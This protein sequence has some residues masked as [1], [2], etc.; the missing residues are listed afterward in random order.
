MG[1][2]MIFGMERKPEKIP[3]STLDNQHVMPTWDSPQREEASILHCY[4][5]LD[6]LDLNT[7][8]ISVEYSSNIFLFIF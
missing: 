1:F 4:T 6:S 8:A 3:N 7:V 5:T 2:G